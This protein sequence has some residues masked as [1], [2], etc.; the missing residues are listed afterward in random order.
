RLRP[1]ILH[2]HTDADGAQRGLPSLARLFGVP[3]RVVTHHGL[4]GWEPW[5]ALTS[6]DAVTAVCASAG[7]ALIRTHGVSR[8]RLRIV[9]HGVDPPDD[10]SELPESRRLRDAIGAG[11]F[12]PLWVCA[13]RLEDIKGHEILLDALHRLMAEGLDFV[14]ALAGEGARRTGLE[15]RAGELG[16][17]QRVHFLGAVES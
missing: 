1:T 6:V 10:A 11:P 5:P 8:A 3:H 15:R 16:L 2:L 13:A 9:T 17:A 7:E 4:P 14:V 12:R